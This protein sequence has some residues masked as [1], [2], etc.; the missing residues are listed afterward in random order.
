MKKHIALLIS[1]VLIVSPIYADTLS[2]LLKGYGD[3]SSALPGPTAS[4][5]SAEN[6]MPAEIEQELQD[7]DYEEIYTVVDKESVQFTCEKSSNYPAYIDTGIKTKNISEEDIFGIIMQI[8]ST[9][10]NKYI[11]DDTDTLLLVKGTLVKVPQQQLNTDELND[12]FKNSEVHFEFK[13]SK[14]NNQFALSDYLE[15]YKDFS[16]IINGEEVSLQKKPFVEN[17]RVL[18]PIREVTEGLGATVKWNRETGIV[19]IKKDNTEFILKE[20]STKLIIKRGEQ[21][22][23]LEEGAIPRIVNVNGEERLYAYI[24]D[25]VKEAGHEV[26]WDASQLAVILK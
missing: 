22:K 3:P 23:T 1:L 19:T 21:V 14:Q 17:N 11:K 6:D 13:Q 7:T 8:A 18:F 24:E 15:T 4:T 9:C 16:F 2:D 26:Y 25:I 20:N 10:E 12:L 5:D